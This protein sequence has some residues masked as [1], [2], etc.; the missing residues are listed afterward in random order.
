VFESA[1]ISSTN[2]SEKLLESSGENATVTKHGFESRWG[3]HTS[4]NRVTLRSF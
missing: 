2:L 4:R 1:R 3:H